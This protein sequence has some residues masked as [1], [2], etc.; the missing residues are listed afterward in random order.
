[1]V[2]P[3]CSSRARRRTGV[4][5]GLARCS[6]AGGGFQLLED[7]GLNRK[8]RRGHVMRE[9]AWETRTL[10]SLHS[11]GGGDGM[12]VSNGPGTQHRGIREAH[13]LGEDGG[14]PV[15]RRPPFGHSAWPSHSLTRERVGGGCPPLGQRALLTRLRQTNMNEARVVS[16]HLETRVMLMGSNVTFKDTHVYRP[17]SPQHQ[18]AG[19]PP[20]CH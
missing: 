8:G 20:C 18:G 3:S 12:S 2:C 11:L 9:A 10:S 4:L 17:C 19:L 5:G 6:V 15:T 16:G 13:R 14:G 7:R 1:M